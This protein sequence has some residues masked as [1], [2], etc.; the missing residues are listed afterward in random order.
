ML[1]VLLELHE[2]PGPRAALRS[3][4]PDGTRVAMP[5]EIT[6]CWETR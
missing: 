4:S 2:P 1:Q 6:L 3:L 5:R